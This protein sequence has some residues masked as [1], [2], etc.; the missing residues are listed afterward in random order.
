MWHRI[1]RPGQHIIFSPIV[2]AY[3]LFV[4]HPDPH[5][6]RS[7]PQAAFSMPALRPQAYG[8]SGARHYQSNPLGLPSVSGAPPVSMVAPRLKPTSSVVDEPPHASPNIEAAVSAIVTHA[9]HITAVCVVDSAVVL[10]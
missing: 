2:I 4:N 10:N 3:F 5:S 9:A 7:V 8:A 6:F 1:E